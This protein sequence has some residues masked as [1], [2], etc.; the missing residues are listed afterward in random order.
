MTNPAVRYDRGSPTIA[1][2]NESSDADVRGLERAVAAIQ[3]QVD[4]DFF[5]LWGWR[6]IL[7]FEPKSTPRR[8]M[9]IT[10]RE[11]DKDDPG[12]LGYH[13][14]DGIPAT[15]VFTRDEKGKP[16]EEFY[17]TLSHEVLEMI[18]DPGVNL[19]AS[20]YYI[21]SG[22]HYRAFLPYEVCDPVQDALYSIDGVKVSDFVVPE[23]FEEERP[24]DS[25]KFS[26]LDSVREPFELA[27]GG[28]I[29]AMVG[30]RVR[31]I[32]GERGKRKKRRHRRKARLVRLGLAKG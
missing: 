26:F 8:A 7:V 28:Y 20:G 25:M 1:I 27:Y 19:Y 10:L 14:I 5:P 12:D 15:Y 13:F 30:Q 32:W 16:L 3:K 9:K 2:F 11:T 17:S 24:R 31:T 6:A 21:K 22:R 29:D 23:W 4:R 18:A